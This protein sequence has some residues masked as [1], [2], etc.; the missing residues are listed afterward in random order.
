MLISQFINPFADGFLVGSIEKPSLFPIQGGIT[1][2]QCR[3]AACERGASGGCERNDGFARQV[4]AFDKSIDDARR[5]VPPD[6]ITD[7]DDI[8]IGNIFLFALE[9]RRRLRGVHL[10]RT[11]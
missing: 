8:A 3:C 11:A 6:R 9:C 1:F 2:L 10:L 7:E 5:E 4:V